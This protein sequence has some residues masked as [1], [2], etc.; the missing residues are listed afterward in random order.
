MALLSRPPTE[1]FSNVR[2]QDQTPY[3]FANVLAIHGLYE[4]HPARR[5]VGKG[6]TISFTRGR[7]TQQS[8]RFQSQ[9]PIHRPSPFLLLTSKD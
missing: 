1:E 4:G 8:L 5:R 7:R 3:L 9:T 2:L 6:D